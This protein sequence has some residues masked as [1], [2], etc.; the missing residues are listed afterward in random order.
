M[1]AMMSLGSLGLERG[2]LGRWSSRGCNEPVLGGNVG[3]GLG[4]RGVKGVGRGR[5]VREDGGGRRRGALVVRANSSYVAPGIVKVNK[6]KINLDEY[7][8]TLEKPIGI[9]FAQ[10]LS[11]KVYVEALAKEGNAEKTMMIFVGD[12]LKK[13]SA[14]FGEGMWDVEDFS[15][16]MQAIKSRSGPV[17]LVFERSQ[18]PVQADLK[19]KAEISFNAGRVAFAT[20]NGNILAY[21]YQGGTVGFLTFS[22]KYVMSK[23]LTSLVNATTVAEPY[24]KFTGRR[25]LGDFEAENDYEIIA[26]ASDEDE[27]EDN[28]T[29]WTF[30]DFNNDEYQAALARAQKDLT[31]NPKRGTS[32]T[33]L[34]DHIYV[35]SCIQSAADVQHLAETLGITAVLNLQRKNEQVNWG[36]NGEEIDNMA[37]QKGLIVVDVPIRDTDTV[38]LRWKLPYAVGVLHRLLRRCHRVYVTCTTGLDRAPSCVIGYLHWIQD[39]S[40][41]QAYEFVTSLHRSGPDRPALVWATWDLIAMVEQGKHEGLPTHSVQFL[42][43]HGCNQGEEVLVV[44]EFT[45]EWTKPIKA[46]HVSGTKYT[47]NLRLPQGRYMYKF[48]VGGHWRHS[49]NLPVDKDQWGNTNNVIQIGNVATSNFNNPYGSQIKDPTIIKVIERPLTEDERFTLA[50]AA[51][52]M[53]FSISPLTFQNKQ[54]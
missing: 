42:W 14:V 31:Y 12:V 5:V 28:E 41:P 21:P 25:Q 17:S 36:I 23:G 50:F 40:L 7:M 18:P 46:N 38:D 45:S 24:V 26:S 32:Y 8:V 13:T 49:Q 19:R 54:S 51:R 27:E 34:T 2:V 10:T 20:W 22:S 6:F 33:K 11:G 53:A 30:G 39:V 4:G 29:E 44:G 35:G 9:R 15:R 37:K 43:N 52:R 47:V 16:S 3:V 48:I 1:D